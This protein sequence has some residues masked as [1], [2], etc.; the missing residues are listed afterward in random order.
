MTLIMPKIEGDTKI[1][2]QQ[3]SDAAAVFSRDVLILTTVI[4]LWSVSYY[5]H[6]SSWRALH[7]PAV[8][9]DFDPRMVRVPADFL[10][11]SLVK[12]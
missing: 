9:A 8:A 11:K 1:M 10:E 3:D 4:G 6:A 12:A 5:E 2:F 7:L